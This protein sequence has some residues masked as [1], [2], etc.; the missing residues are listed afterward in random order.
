MKQLIREL[1]EVSIEEKDNILADIY[2]KYGKL[3]YSIVYDISKDHECALEKSNDIILYIWK[4]Q[5][6]LNE[7]EN[8]L[9]YLNKILYNWGIDYYRSNKSKIIC[10]IDEIAID[11]LSNKNDEIKKL[12]DK[13]SVDEILSRLKEDERDVIV[14]KYGYN[15]TLSEIAKTLNISIKKVR[16][17]LERANSK[18]KYIQENYKKGVN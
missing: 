14:L 11:T 12:E 4:N 13:L 2:N 5:K 6:K 10:Y 16:V 3:F 8:P 9:S 1:L 15:Q 7:L 18:I 17:R